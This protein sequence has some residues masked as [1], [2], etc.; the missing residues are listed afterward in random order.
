MQRKKTKKV[1]V[2]N[3]Y[4][5]GDSPVTIQSMTNTKTANIKDTIEQIKLL[6]K[7][8]CEIIRVAVP[9]EES[10]QAIKKLKRKST[11]H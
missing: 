10:A 7:A 6:E 2:G 11:S 3:I 9:D 1:K 8:G 5:G 4:I